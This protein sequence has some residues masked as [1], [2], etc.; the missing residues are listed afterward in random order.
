[1]IHS[2]HDR[3]LIEKFLNKVAFFKDI[4]EKSLEQVIDDFSITHATKNEV[5][6]VQEDTSTDLYII[7]KGRVKV[8]LMS[9]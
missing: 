8:T 3:A 5:I 9:E 2:K 4:T 7:L 1:M 6:I